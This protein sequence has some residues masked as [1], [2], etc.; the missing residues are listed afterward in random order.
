MSAYCCPKC[1][2][3]NVLYV[4]IR[5]VRRDYEIVNHYD[6]RIVVNDDP[7]NEEGIDSMGNEDRFECRS[8][9]AEWW[10]DDAEIDWDLDP[11]LAE[12]VKNSKA[13]DPT[14][15][16]AMSFLRDALNDGIE[17]GDWYHVREL[18]ETYYA[19]AEDEDGEDE[20][21]VTP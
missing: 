1:G 9:K 17:D 14:I 12:A 6:D 8:C 5:R 13:E 20:E 18:V 19:D 16:Q 2:S 11:S 10:P 21:E 3:E 4:E 7:T 15:A